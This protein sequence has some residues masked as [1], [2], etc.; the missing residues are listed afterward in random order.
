VSPRGSGCPHA[1]RRAPQV[2][3]GLEQNGC[4][5]TEDDCKL[6]TGGESL[7]AAGLAATPARPNQRT[8]QAKHSS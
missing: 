1:A 3:P 7:V 4:N 6:V 2:L 5:Q 8:N